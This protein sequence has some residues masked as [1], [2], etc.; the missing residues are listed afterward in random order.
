MKLK[1]RVFIFSLTPVIATKT[2]PPF[3]PH[4]G[5]IS[6]DYTAGYLTSRLSPPISNGFN[7]QVA[8]NFIKLSSTCRYLTST[9]EL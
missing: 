8:G 7:N 6:S 4:E 5:S 9:D 3:T 1:P 2:F